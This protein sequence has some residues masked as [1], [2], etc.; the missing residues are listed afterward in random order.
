MQHYKP[1]YMQFGNKG[2]VVFFL[3]GYGGNINSFKKSAISLGKDFKSYVF[4]LYGFG[5][6]PHP[7]KKMD[8]YEYAIQIYLFC[9]KKK[10]S[11]L[12]IVGHSFGG[13]IAILLSSV[14]GINVEKLILV[15]S[16][17]LKPRRGLVYYVKVGLYKLSKKRIG[18]QNRFYGSEE[19]R[20]IEG[21]KQQSFVA[22]VNQ[23]L[24]YLLYKI[25]VD[26]LIVWGSRDK[27]TPMYMFKKF[28]NNLVN[29]ESCVFKNSNH[30]SY[31]QNI[32]K[33]NMIINRFLKR[34]IDIA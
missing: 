34:G 8:I 30:F 25:R 24:D 2:N 20:Q 11:K 29:A 17:G 28:L 16:A 13:R 5:S 22:I 21:F 9:I 4:D 1:N 6:T 19:Y 14:F 32:Y 12:S 26:T 18:K 23:H 15:D 27:S 33:F 31:M 3:H 7:K 10:I